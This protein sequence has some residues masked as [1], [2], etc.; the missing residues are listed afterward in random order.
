MG[1]AY[2][3]FLAFNK[4]QRPKGDGGTTRSTTDTMDDPVEEARK[5]MEKYK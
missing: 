4:D 1:L 3:V 5:I 2:F